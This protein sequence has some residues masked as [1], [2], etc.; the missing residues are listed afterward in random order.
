MV[1]GLL[2]SETVRFDGDRAA[3]RAATV[4]HALQGLVERIARTPAD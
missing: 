2:S 4:R 1:D 3:I